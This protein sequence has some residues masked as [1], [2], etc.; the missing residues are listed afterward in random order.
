MKNSSKTMKTSLFLA[1]IF[2]LASSSAFAV[3]PITP[4]SET[5]KISIHEDVFVTGSQDSYT[6]TEKHSMNYTSPNTITVNVDGEDVFSDSLKKAMINYTNDINAI[7]GETHVV[8]DFAYDLS[9]DNTTPNLKTTSKINFQGSSLSKTEKAETGISEIK[10]FR[11]Y[12]D[13]HNNTCINKNGACWDAAVGSSMVVS[14]IESSSKIDLDITHTPYIHNMIAASGDGSIKSGMEATLKEGFERIY[15]KGNLCP[16]S[17]SKVTDMH[18]NTHTYAN[19]QFKF[20][21]DVKNVIN[22]L[23]ANKPTDN[24]DKVP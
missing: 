22:N 23:N 5:S 17:T 2:L 10:G 8:E 9:S 11:D 4:D 16:L 6:K 13:G 19:G 20:S 14:Y 18:Y 12:T 1:S 15:T 24:I 21:K 3:D 7:N